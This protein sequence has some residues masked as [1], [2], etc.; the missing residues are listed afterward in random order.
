MSEQLSD[1]QKVEPTMV[2]K[3]MTNTG[4][5]TR[6]WDA[7]PRLEDETDDDGVVVALAGTTLELEPGESALVAVPSDFEDPWLKEAKVGAPKKVR[8]RK[9]STSG[10]TEG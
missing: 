3:T 7:I 1:E 10:Q 9:A 4:F 8:S 6:R 2:E 5:H